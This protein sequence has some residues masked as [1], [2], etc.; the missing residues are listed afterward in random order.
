MPA[1]GITWF[2]AARFVNWLNTSNGHSPAYKFVDNSFDL[3]NSGDPGY[4]PNNP[5]RNRH[6]IF[7]LPSAD[8]WYKAAY[9]DPTSGTYYDFPTGANSKPTKVSSGTAA[10]TAVYAMSINHGPA[11][12]T[13]AGGLS[14][15]GTMGQ[16][17]N[18]W[19]WE[20]TESDLINDSSLSFRGVRGGGWYGGD[21]SLDASTRSDDHPTVEFF[22]VGFRVATVPEPG[23]ATLVG[24]GLAVLGIIRPCRRPRLSAP[25]GSRQQ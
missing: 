15:Y 22:S 18:V 7:V 4:N 1:T 12:I 2:E 14:P 21:I 24:L 23:T 5:F 11:D 3:W 10:D 8:E 16:G 9:Y 13:S 25:T 6:A 20:E 17:G 19:E